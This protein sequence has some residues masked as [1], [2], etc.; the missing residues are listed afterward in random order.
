M[1]PSPATVGQPS[2]EY[3]RG[4]NAINRLI[5]RGFSWSGNERHTAFANLGEGRF[6]NASSVSGFDYTDDGRALALADWNRDGRPD[7]ILTNRNA[8]R[9]R[10]LLG[11]QRTPGLAL[12]LVGRTPNRD[13]IGARVTVEL[14]V[15]ASAEDAG[16][17]RRLVR[18]VR[19]GEGYLAQSSPWLFFGGGKE[20]VSRVSV[21]WPD[22][23]LEGFEGL[24][25]SGSF[26]LERGSGVARRLRPLDGAAGARELASERDEEPARLESGAVRLVLAHPVP[27]P[28]LTLR[29]AGGEPLTLFGVQPG[30]S[31]TG[32]G[33][34]VLLN[35]WASWCAP[36]IQELDGFLTRREE[37]EATG[38]ALLVA[39]VDE[40][41]EDARERLSK[42]GWP[43]A[44][45]FLDADAL[46]VL[47][48]MAGALR[49][50]ERPL[51]LPT[52]FLIDGQG[53]LRAVYFGAVEPDVLLADR[54][55]C[56]LPREALRERATPFVGS[57][58][59]PAL[60]SDLS[61]FERKFEARGLPSVAQEYGLQR[62]ET[63][64]AS[65]A[66]LL[67][68]F[69]RRRAEQGDLVEARRLYEEA[70]QEEPESFRA[71]AD[72]GVLLHRE[73]SWKEAVRYYSRA[74]ATDPEHPD[75][76]F[77]RGLAYAQL[78]DVV[79]AERD[80]TRL[81]EMNSPLAA[82]LAKA[83]ETATRSEER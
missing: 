60:G 22:G 54:A 72:M 35:L 39:S 71:N 17:T 53:E 68:D 7:V 41:P 40:V 26:E 14:E 38:L 37:L 23:V 77:N 34:P 81:R 48:V 6:A 20:R 10:M 50:S 80:L 1:S 36:C 59:S 61:F 15:P 4:W 52:S 31:G 2:A 69:A 33:R 46:D 43:Y 70:L 67:I 78:G 24:Q 45:G 58:R 75:T 12:R 56:E 64:T 30:G 21:R 65:R 25:R 47:D 76:R 62:V 13:A 8:P 83:I 29:P 27:M 82:S 19:A 9:W 11:K 55:L 49:D 28:K 66:K 44:W 5:R 16:S 74:L 51:E 3:S 32:T 42:L 18:A 57:W 79:A 73:G 63:K